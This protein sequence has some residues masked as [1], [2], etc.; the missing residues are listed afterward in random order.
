MSRITPP[1]GGSHWRHRHHP[2]YAARSVA[3]AAPG[4][5]PAAAPTCGGL[6]PGVV[7]LPIGQIDR[8]IRPTDAQIPVLNDLETAAA[9]AGKILQSSCPAEVPLTP[10]GRLDAVASR[11]QAM[12]EAVQILRPALATLYNSLDDA[13]KQRFAA[14]GAQGEYGRARTAGEASP[15]G[16][17][18]ALCNRSETSRCCRCSASKTRSNRRNSR[19][20]HSTR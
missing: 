6:A 19:N 8:A 17:L 11:I 18:A 2:R 12:I 13:Q 15:A 16:D 4:T 1:M 10:V 3:E 5:E 20:S 9:R 14:I 7:N